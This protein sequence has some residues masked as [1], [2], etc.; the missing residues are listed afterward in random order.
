MKPYRLWEANR[1]AFA[2]PENYAEH[3][4]KVDL[5]S[6]GAR[7]SQEGGNVWRVRAH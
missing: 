1:R 6:A 7:L 2:Y 4:I 5:A 3:V